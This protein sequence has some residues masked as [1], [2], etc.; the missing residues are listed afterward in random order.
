MARDVRRAPARLN[1]ALA[2]LAAGF[3]ALGWLAWQGRAEELALAADRQAAVQ[4]AATHAINLM[5][6]DH[7]SIDSTLNRILAT[8]TGEAKAGYQGTMR[9]VALANK[10]QQTGV[11]RAAGLASYNA[12][13]AQVLVV[14]DAVI[15]WADR[16][17][18][19]EERFT[20]WRMTVVKESGKW[21]VSRAE[22]VP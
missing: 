2:M 3:T 8:S 5:S 10:V 20:R 15:D 7:R 9:E 1:A 11:L 13:S 12:R 16:D 19:A 6:L 4:A 18:P 14:A 17:D 21:L 22:L